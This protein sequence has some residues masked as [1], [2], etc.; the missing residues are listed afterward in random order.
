[1]YQ[2]L[3]GYDLRQ[4]KEMV[5]RNGWKNVQLS[6]DDIR[7]ENDMQTLTGGCP[8]CHGSRKESVNGIL[9]RCRFCGSS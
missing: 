2:K 7:R 1:M 8:Y 3:Q 9:V 6:L 5:E 4:L